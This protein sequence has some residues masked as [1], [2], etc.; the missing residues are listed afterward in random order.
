MTSYKEIY[1]CFTIW[2]LDN[3]L[4]DMASISGIHLMCYTQLYKLAWLHSVIEMIEKATGSPA[5]G[6]HIVDLLVELSD[7][8]K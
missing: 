7:W 6:E 2:R 4:D 3:R 8:Q 1:I 5:N